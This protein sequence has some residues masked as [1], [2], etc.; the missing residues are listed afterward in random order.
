MYITICKIDDQCKFDTLSRAFKARHTREGGGREVEG[1]S[2]WGETC[3]PVAD[4][5]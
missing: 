1:G 3:M 5:C 2:G 4:S